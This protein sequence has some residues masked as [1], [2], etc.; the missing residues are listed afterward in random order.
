MDKAKSKK[1]PKA[2]PWLRGVWII[3]AVLLCNPVSLMC[4][5]SVSGFF[6]VIRLSLYS[7][8]LF[9]HPLPPDTVEISQKADIY[10]WGGSDTYCTFNVTRVI[11]SSLSEEELGLFFGQSRLPTPRNDF[12][13][14]FYNEGGDGECRNYSLI[15]VIPDKEDKTTFALN[16]SA[17]YLKSDIFGCGDD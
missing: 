2:R 12:T 3:M 6:D 14:R 15:H 10:F 4:F 9:S 16:I 13:C 7:S 1:H 5:G 11:Q 8:A 17:I